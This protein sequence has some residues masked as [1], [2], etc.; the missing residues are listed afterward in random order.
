MRGS[1][2]DASVDRQIDRRIVR[3]AV[4]ALGSLAVEPLYVLVD[5]AIVG[6]LGTAQLGGLAV[7]AAVLGLVVAGCN[8]LTYGTTERVARR[9]GA[10]DRGEAADVGLQA[11]WLS[12]LVGVAVA[13][14]VALSAGSVARLLGA[15]GDV[16]GFATTYLR[17]SAVGLPFVVFAL[18]AQGVQ[19]GATD[20]RTPLVILV[21]ANV[22][23]AVLEVLFVFGFD[24]GVPGSAWSTVIVQVAAGVAFAVVIRRHLAPARRRRPDLAAMTPL[25]SA[26]KHLLLRVGSMLVV[27]SGATA[28]A[29]RTDAPTLAAHQI[30]ASLLLLASL[31]LDALAIP[32]QTLVAEQL[33]GHDVSGAALLA[34][35]CAVLSVRVAVVAAAVLAV[36][37]PLIPRLFTSD[38]A[39]IDRATSIMWF[40]AAML[41]PAAVAFAYD[42]VL[43]GAGDYRFLGVAALAYLVAVAPV[44]VATLVGQWGI[45]GIWSGLALWML[46]RAIV[47]HRR[48]VRL[49][50]A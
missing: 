11:V 17:I 44:G 39:V 25:L 21:I 2:L 13:P 34:R 42:G 50:P 3:L 10:G 1:R 26:G 8:F 47:N 12:L 33:G 22:A 31:A 24:W 35:R 4:P 29:A 19:R 49:L 15:S 18:A 43:I 27:L 20:Y 45:A 14:I 7:S 36:A 37:S 5:T 48:V 9:I 6:R 38:P 32:A 40:L 30:G 23:N 28:I 16:L 46:L 41:L